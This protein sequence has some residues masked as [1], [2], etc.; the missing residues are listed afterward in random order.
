M[1]CY[2][3]RFSSKLLMIPQAA[4]VTVTTDGKPVRILPDQTDGQTDASQDYRFTSVMNVSGGAGNPAAQLIIQGSVDGVIWFE[5]ATGTSRTAP[6]LYAE[7]IDAP[8]SL[9]LPWV[10]VR[11]AIVGTTPPSVDALV[12]VVST[13]PFQ[14][15]A[16]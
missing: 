11:V 5:V 3:N 6:G 10:R 4:P 13:G 14:L 15:S 12:D 1:K 8:N 9:L 7:I 2:P 16:G